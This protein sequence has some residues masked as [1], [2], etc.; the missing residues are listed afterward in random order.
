MR[1]RRI[2]GIVMMFILEC[3]I[4]INPEGDARECP[5]NVLKVGSRSR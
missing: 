2:V 5:E 4:Y 3:D 1:G